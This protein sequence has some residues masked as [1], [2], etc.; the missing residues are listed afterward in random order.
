MGNPL[1]LRRHKN[2]TPEYLFLNEMN[3][4]TWR[5]L[6]DGNLAQ[7]GHFI[8]IYGGLSPDSQE[9]L[10]VPKGARRW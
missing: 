10:K 1:T 5:V 9:A 4:D 6:G 3:V 7:Q 2:L 8:H